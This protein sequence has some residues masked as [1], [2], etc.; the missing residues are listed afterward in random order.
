MNEFPFIGRDSVKK[1]LRR[2]IMRDNRHIAINGL[3]QIGKTRILGEIK[4]SLSKLTEQHYIKLFTIFS[5]DSFRKTMLVIYEDLMKE[6]PP[7]SDIPDPKSAETDADVVMQLRN[8]LRQISSP[9]RKVILMLDEFERAFAGDNGWQEEQYNLF[10]RKLVLDDELD[11]K[12][13]WIVASRPLLDNILREKEYAQRLNP[14]VSFTIKSFNKTDMEKYFKRVESILGRA[15]DAEEELL[16]RKYCGRY[17]KLLVLTASFLER[18][19]LSGPVNVSNVLM[20]LK[21]RFEDHFDDVI[22]VIVREERTMMH[23]FSNLIRCYFSPSEDDDEL[24]CR[25]RDLGYMEPYRLPDESPTE[26]DYPY[27]DMTVSPTFVYYL[28]KKYLDRAKTS[29]GTDVDGIK[30]PKVLLSGLVG[31]LRRITRKKLSAELGENWNET[32]LFDHCVCKENGQLYRYKISK[33]NGL[34]A[35]DHEDDPLPPDHPTQELIELTTPVYF[36]HDRYNKSDT[37]VLDPINLNDHARI[38]LHFAVLFSSYFEQAFGSVD[39]PQQFENTMKRLK[40]SRDEFAHYLFSG[41]AAPTGN[42][43]TAGDCKKL[44]CSIYSYI[45]DSAEYDQWL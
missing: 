14:F 34:I 13:I 41:I 30:D 3:P 11:G 9:T 23:S 27:L 45:V 7:I 24:K 44:L 19:H 29:H 25:F 1:K 22:D 37:W 33:W 35:I 31:L 10:V 8:L 17:P 5:G 26:D 12:V 20:G 43:D 42:G 16:V 18:Q 40:R 36:F 32:L 6:E 39:F 28:F 4:S 15:L 21:G 2:Q 38:I